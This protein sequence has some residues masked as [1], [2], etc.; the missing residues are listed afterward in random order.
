MK[1]LPPSASDPRSF[2][3]NIGPKP[4]ALWDTQYDVAVVRDNAPLPPPDTR[5]PRCPT[6]VW[7]RRKEAVT[8]ERKGAAVGKLWW[9][10]R[11][12]K[13]VV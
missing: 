4:N 7:R 2:Y 8:R 13:W 1:Q 6:C 12:W 11:R 10:G 9:C 3:L 5:P